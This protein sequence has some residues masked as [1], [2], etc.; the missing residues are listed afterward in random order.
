MHSLYV[1]FLSGV[2]AHVECSNQ[3]SVY[4]HVDGVEIT[5]DSIDHK[6]TS[7]IPRAARLI[8]IEAESMADEKYISASFSNGYKTSKQWKCS[9]EE[10]S[11]WTSV[12]FVEDNSWT[13]ANETNT[14]TN[15]IWEDGDGD[16]VYCRGWIGK[17][18]IH[19]L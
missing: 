17:A 14:G 8:A 18:I 4:V 11:G 15:H 16:K 1:H 7:I 13:H 6:L 19:T 12:L 10:E 5:D 3:G 2:N 9:T